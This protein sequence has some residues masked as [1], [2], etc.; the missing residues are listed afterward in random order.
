VSRISKDT[1]VCDLM[2]LAEGLRLP[3]L[4]ASVSTPTMKEKTSR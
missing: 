4:H 3:W 1:V 2:V